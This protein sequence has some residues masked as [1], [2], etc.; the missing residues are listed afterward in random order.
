MS[1]APPSSPFHAGAPPKVTPFSTSCSRARQGPGLLSRD[2]HRQNVE[3]RAHL[4][5]FFEK[6]YPLPTA[7]GGAVD[8][9]GGQ[10]PVA[11]RRRRQRQHAGE[12]DEED[13]E[14]EGEDNAGRNGK[15][16][17]PGDGGD[18]GSGRSG[19]ADDGFVPGMWSLEQLVMTLLEGCLNAH[20]ASGAGAGASA[21]G[22]GGDTGETDG[23]NGGSYVAL[24]VAKHW[25]RY[26]AILEQSGVVE[27]HPADPNRIRMV[28]FAA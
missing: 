15:R 17:R 26:V 1:F 18:G 21:S 4:H 19:G 3:L 10:R 20:E 8:E 13:G 22:G 24:D 27:R 7:A 28:M 11:K 2:L 12:G 23:A 14:G 5:N 25:P 9:D 6:Y 16:R